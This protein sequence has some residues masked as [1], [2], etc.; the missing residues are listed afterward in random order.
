MLDPSRGFLH[1]CSAALHSRGGKG[2][3]PSLKGCLRIGVRI[4]ANKY[5]DSHKLPLGYNSKVATGMVG[6]AN[7]G[8]T[9]YLNALLQV[10]STKRVRPI[11]YFLT[12]FIDVVSYSRLPKGG[13]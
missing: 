4:M 9:C 13:V 6:L 10:Q 12:S 3:T 7:L 5:L 11:N 8:A 2:V 1:P